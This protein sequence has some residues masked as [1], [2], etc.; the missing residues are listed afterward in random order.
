[1]RQ[2]TMLRDKTKSLFELYMEIWEQGVDMLEDYIRFGKQPIENLTERQQRSSYFS[3]PTKKD[4]QIFLEKN[5]F[6]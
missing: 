5:R 4:V 1:L 3:W 2:K 6:F